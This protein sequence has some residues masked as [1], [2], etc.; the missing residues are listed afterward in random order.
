MRK[1]SHL[2][3]GST[4]LA[5]DGTATGG[6]TTTA[7]TTPQAGTNPPAPAPQA[8][9]A[10]QGSSTPATEPGRV[11]DLPDWAQGMIG[12]LRKENAGHR[13]KA[14]E[15]TEAAQRAEEQRLASQQQW[16]QLAESRQARLDELEPKSAL[17][18]TLTER[19]ATRINEEIKDWPA[20][21]VALLPK[22]APVLEYEAAV[23]NARPL[24]ERLTAKPAPTPGTGPRPMPAGQAGAGEQRQQARKQER[25]FVQRTF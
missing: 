14:K 9:A 3:F 12:E 19:I 21:V 20:E 13:T 17:A 5:A 2:L 1:H 7:N 6:T 24:V 23:A 16:Q 11:E 18:D 10:G 15:A 25:A 4:Y 8:G 22:D